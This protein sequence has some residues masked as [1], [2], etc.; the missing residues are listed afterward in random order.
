M[1]KALRA[2]LEARGVTPERIAELD[3]KIRN[4]RRRKADQLRRDLG[5]VKVRGALGGTYWE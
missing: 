3:R 1:Q 5:L 4:L 2:E